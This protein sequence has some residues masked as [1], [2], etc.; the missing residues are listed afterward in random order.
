[1]SA[2]NRSG[3]RQS[4]RLQAREEQ[5]RK[6][7][8][9]DYQRIKRGVDERLDLLGINQDDCNAMT[10]AQIKKWAD[11]HC[12]SAAKELS[13]QRRKGDMITVLLEGCKLR[14]DVERKA[15]EKVRERALGNGVSADELDQFDWPGIND[16]N[17]NAGSGNVNDVNLENGD[18][19][20]AAPGGA[21][22]AEVNGQNINILVD[23]LMRENF[24]EMRD[25]LKKVRDELKRA[26]AQIERLE[27]GDMKEENEN[28]N[29]DE[30][31][32]GA[33][34]ELSGASRAQ[35]RSKLDELLGKNPKPLH[36]SNVFIYWLHIGAHCFF[37]NCNFIYI[38]LSVSAPKFCF[39]SI[40]VFVF[41]VNLFYII[42][43]FYYNY[44]VYSIPIWVH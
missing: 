21:A 36:V 15:L 8:I 25:E 10:I 31:K 30:R 29:S 41:W 39:F 28:K 26:N 32:E 35:L 24:G 20:G 34:G 44:F 6:K 16:P 12:P 22:P 2:E 33:G 18:Q 7:L 5:N 38:I 4:E 23:K 1:M 37:F 43:C 40:F 27:K 13:K 17:D 3:G 9:D 14:M 11:E 42:S 19:P